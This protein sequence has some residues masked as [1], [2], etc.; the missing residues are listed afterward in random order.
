MVAGRQTEAPKR[1]SAQ[2]RTSAEI[3][4]QSAKPAREGDLGLFLC[5]GGREGLLLLL[6]HLRD[7]ARALDRE[8]L[9][10]AVR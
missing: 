9:H 7:G 1:S 6:E 3:G 2:Q 10:F 8:L 5:G 4:R